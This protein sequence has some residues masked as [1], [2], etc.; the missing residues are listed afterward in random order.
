[1]SGC[2]SPILNKKTLVTVTISTKSEDAAAILIDLSSSTPAANPLAN[3][4]VTNSVGQS[5]ALCTATV[6]FNASRGIDPAPNTPPPSAPPPVPPAAP[7]WNLLGGAGGLDVL[8]FVNVS[9]PAAKA[10]TQLLEANKE[11]V[12]A[13]AG[14]VVAAGVA[15]SAAAGAVRAGAAASGAGGPAALAGAQ[16]NADS[17]RLLCGLKWAQVKSEGFAPD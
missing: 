7:P 4:P 17:D 5:F 6:V 9:N 8:E 2:S 12:K 1:M 11:T 13:A 15:A 14:V 3:A 10:L 16:R